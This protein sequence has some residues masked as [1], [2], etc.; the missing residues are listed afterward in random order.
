[1]HTHQAFALRRSP[2]RRG[3][4]GRQALLWLQHQVHSECCLPGLRIEL[5]DQGAM[6]W[7]RD[8][9]VDMDGASRIQPWDICLVAIITV[10]ADSLRGTVGII[11]L[12][13]RVRRPPFQ[14][15]VAERGTRRGSADRARNDQTLPGLRPYRGLGNVHRTKCIRG[16]RRTRGL[17]QDAL[18]KQHALHEADH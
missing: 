15:R 17:R 10:G 7:R 8:A 12:A 9:H 11:V 6:A 14:L 2:S 5:R 18:G 16:S 13:L 3:Q 1:M 4:M